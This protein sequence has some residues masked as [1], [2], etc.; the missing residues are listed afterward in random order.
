LFTMW[1]GY[2]GPLPAHARS[3]GLLPRVLPATPRARR[4]LILRLKPKI[5]IGFKKTI[6][7]RQLVRQTFVSVSF[8]VCESPQTEPLILNNN[9][10]APQFDPASDSPPLLALY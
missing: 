5:S 7:E 4:R 1:K 6:Q 9:C 10:I 3:S 2:D 8:F